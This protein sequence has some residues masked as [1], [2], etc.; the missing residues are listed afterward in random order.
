MPTSGLT[1]L[2]GRVLAGRYR[3]VAPL[4]S[5]ASGRVY[6]ADDVRLRR[7]VAVKVLHA[8]L[9]DDAGF[10]KRFRMEAQI[11]G[12]LHHRNVM[13][14]YDWGEDPPGGGV[15]FMVLE[16]L[17]GGSLRS[18]LDRGVLLTPA[19]AAHVGVEVANALEYAHTRGLV[20]RDIKPANLLFDEHGI[21][22]VAD[23]GLARAL[24]EASWT[25]PT[26]SVVGTAR[27]AAP[28][29]ARGTALDGRA[30]LYALGLV[31]VEAVTGEVP[32]ARDTPIGT[33][34][35]RIDQP[36]AA[37]P[38]LGPLGAIVERV[39][40]PDPAER[41]QDA[42][43]MGAA[44]FDVA[45]RLPPP[46]PLP[47]GSAFAGDDPHPTEVK[48]AS[49][50]VVDGDS[51][52]VMSTVAAPT[53]VDRYLRP[54]LRSLHRNIIPTVVSILLVLALGAS[55]Y[56]VNAAGGARTVAPNFV[57]STENA[58][59]LAA[60][61]HRPALEVTVSRKI[62]S[63]DPAGLVIGQDPAPGAWMKTRGAIHLTVSKGPP[64]IPVPQVAAQKDVDAVNALRQAGFDVSVTPQFDDTIKKGLV[65]GTEPEGGKNAPRGS[66]ITL[67]VS[68]GPKPVPVPN[69]VGQT[70]E[71]AAKTLSDAHLG[72]TR[73]DDFSETVD[74]GK[75]ISQDPASGEAP[76]DSKVTL[77]VSKGPERISV[78]DLTGLSLDDA[79]SALDAAGLQLGTVDHWR[80]DRVVKAQDPSPGDKVKRGTS[81]DLLFGD[82]H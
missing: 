73:V 1:D 69:V 10:L 40:R 66:T 65:I 74:S 45:R 52:L 35:A 12:S 59:I 6:V 25:E 36:V 58:A 49:A 61:K 5:G 19:Q 75:V 18:M 54:A 77:H 29:Q 76:K 14:V 68:Q 22:R 17:E 50:I 27:Y 23:F 4:G 72:V 56:A 34:A 7:R 53:A 16:L 20:H 11:A 48:V 47:I 24:A 44:L 9:A 39:G 82:K 15:P 60:S 78:P 28:E 57:G 38:E 8:A 46:A 70:F 81:V 67:F 55:A 63:D 33:L 37:P 2:A 79:Q 21:V 43:T 3:L 13:T 51:D 80:K 26:G 31:L 32:F 64:P 62:V 71:D 30:D 41:Y 42:A